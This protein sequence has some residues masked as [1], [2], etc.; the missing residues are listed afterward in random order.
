MKTNFDKA[1]TQGRNY[2]T[3]DED[4]RNY[5][6]EFGLAAL[7]P[8]N[9]VQCLHAVSNCTALDPATGL[10]G[11]VREKVHQFSLA[12]IGQPPTTCADC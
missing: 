5:G 10:H 1:M 11:V 8:E 9:F 12:M 3:T 7:A 4:V 6:A 2:I